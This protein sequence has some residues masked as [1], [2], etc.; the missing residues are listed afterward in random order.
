[1]ADSIH[2]QRSRAGQ[3]AL[4]TG[5]SAGLGVEIATAL[6][7]AGSEVVLASRS[8]RRCEEAAAQVS[9]QTGAAG[10]RPGV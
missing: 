4:V 2:G 3:V 1:M 10:Y 5:G 6:A 7:Q 8:A 9:A